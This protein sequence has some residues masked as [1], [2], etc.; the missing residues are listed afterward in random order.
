MSDDERISVDLAGLHRLAGDLEDVLKKLN[1]S[2]DA[3][4]GRVAKLVLTWEGEAR[5]VFV[6]E[7]DKWDRSAQDLEAAQAWLHE[8]VTTGSTNYA[9]AH[10]AVL[11]GWGGH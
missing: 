7:L 9:A 10:R 8:V 3:L 4:Y 6:D 11:Q 1:E 2:L 5:E